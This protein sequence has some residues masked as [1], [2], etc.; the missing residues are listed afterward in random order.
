MRLRVS[1]DQLRVFA[2]SWLLQTCSGVPFC[3]RSRKYAADHVHVGTETRPSHLTSPVSA[4]RTDQRIRLTINVPDADPSLGCEAYVVGA[5]YF[6]ARN[7]CGTDASCG[8]VKSC[9]DETGPNAAIHHFR[10]MRQ[11]DLDRRRRCGILEKLKPRRGFPQWRG[12]RMGR[13][14]LQVAVR[15][16]VQ[17]GVVIVCKALAHG[18]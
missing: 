14:M 13:S 10:A 18:L 9:R 16:D 15:A 12:R 7:E 8:C 2:R 1:A 4:L 5:H 17:A 6:S 11:E 3:T